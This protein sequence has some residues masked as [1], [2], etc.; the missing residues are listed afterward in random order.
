MQI[1]CQLQRSLATDIKRGKGRN[2]HCCNLILC[3]SFF[4]SSTVAD[5]FRLVGRFLIE[6]N[7]RGRHGSGNGQGKNSSRS[8]NSTLSQGKFTS[9]KNLGKSEI[10]EYKLILFSTVVHFTDTNHVLLVEYCS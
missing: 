6:D 9:S 1:S 3:S 5:V 2:I 7:K 4:F 10:L 8:E